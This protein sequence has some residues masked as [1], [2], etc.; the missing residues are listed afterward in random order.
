CLAEQKHLELQRSF[1]I[2]SSIITNDS[3]RLRQILLN[4]LSNAIKFTEVGKVEVRVWELGSDRIAIAVEDTGI[5]IAPED[6]QSIF[7]PFRQGN[8]TLTRQHGGTGLGLAITDSLVKMMGGKI[9]VESQL[10]EGTTF[11]VE[12]PRQVGQQ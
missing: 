8:Q 9:S 10:G 5:G 4:L 11:Y 2:Q 3:V 12:L 6:L 1:A 7:Q